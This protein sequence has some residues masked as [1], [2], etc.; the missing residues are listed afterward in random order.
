[1]S[2][3]LTNLFRA[4]LVWG[5]VKVPREIA[6][7]SS[8]GFCGTMGVITTLELLQHHFAKMG[9]RDLLVTHNLFHRT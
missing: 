8:V 6:D 4:K 7:D 5:S 1:M 2:L 9:H 3:V